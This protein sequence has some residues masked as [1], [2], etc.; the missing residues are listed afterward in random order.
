VCL[1]LQGQSVLLW[2][3][4]ALGYGVPAVAKSVSAVVAL[5]YGVRAVARSVS[6]VVALGYGVPAVARSV[7]VVVACY[8]LRLRCACRC[9]VSQCCCGLLWP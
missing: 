3:V 6:A 4:M 5:G 9:K 7:S 2:P 1:P 8:G